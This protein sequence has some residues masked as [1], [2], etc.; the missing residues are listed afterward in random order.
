M[1]PAHVAIIMDGNGRWGKK[2]LITRNAGHK[3]GAQN[4][5]V[6]T[7]EA[8]K[9]GIKFLTVFAFSTENWTR[10]KDE[11]DGLMRLIPEYIQQYIDENNKNNMRFSVIGDLTRLDSNLCE[12]INN[13]ETMTKNKTGLHL[14]V[15]LNYGG[16]DDI[17][18]AAKK[19][20]YMIKKGDIEP[21]QIDA[22]FFCGLLDTARFPDPD[23]LI[24]TGNESRISNFFL[25]QSAYTEIYFSEKLFPDFNVRDLRD[26]VAFFSGRDRRYGGVKE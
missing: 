15:A 6:L 18:R 17:V 14:I 25:W 26:A 5:R 20:A 11:V 4:L 3:A 22:S 2:R 16:R 1:I 24:R 21:E 7:E 9:I 8:E 23:M 12:K 13:L 10:P 19:A